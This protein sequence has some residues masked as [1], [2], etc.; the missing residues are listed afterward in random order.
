MNYVVVDGD[1]VNIII[2]II[3]IIIAFQWRSVL[4][5][6]KEMLIADHNM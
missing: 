3:I 5:T 6:D 1:D 4:T 2:I